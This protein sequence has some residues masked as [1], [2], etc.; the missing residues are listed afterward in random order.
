MMIK[1]IQHIA[2]A[3]E[4]LQK[5]AQWY[6]DVFGLSLEGLEE[7]QEMKTKV[8]FFKV[9]ETNIELVQPTSEETGLAK[10]LATRGPGIHHLCLEVD[11]TEYEL[12]RLREK[13]VQLID[14]TPRRGAHGMKVAFLHPK[15]SGGILIELCQAPKEE[16]NEDS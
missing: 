1:K 7:L 8:G 12:N 3:V 16:K 10:F 15:A 5:A 13:G 9:G 2:I 11:D 14:Q 6:Q 4:N